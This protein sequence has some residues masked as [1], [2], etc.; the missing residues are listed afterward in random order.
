MTL[1]PKPMPPSW[2]YLSP[3]FDDVALSCGGLVWEQAQDGESVSVWTICA[4]NAPESGLSPFAESL[5]QR[6]QTGAQAPEQRRLEDLASCKVMNAAARHFD[7][8]DCIYRADAEGNLLYASENAIFEPLHP[9]EAPLVDRL[10]QEL[11]SLLPEGARLVSPLSLGGHVDHRLVRQVAV[12]VAGAARLP[13]WFYA[14]YPYI[15]G[16]SDQLSGLVNLAW[17][18]HTFPVSTGGLI[19]WQNAIAAHASQIST[20]WSD[21]DAMCTAIESYLQQQNGVILWKGELA[22]LF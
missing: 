18:A 1:A 7:L 15:L 21:P 2:I 20:F 5:H 17:T 10:S 3:H 22:D 4:G 6:W 19:A 11:L 12:Q 13:V 8:P 14:D 16:H 9:L